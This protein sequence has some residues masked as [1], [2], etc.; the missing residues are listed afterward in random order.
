M[1]GRFSESPIDDVAAAVQIVRT[2]KNVLTQAAPSDRL[3]FSTRLDVT[4]G[5][6]FTERWDLNTSTIQRKKFGTGDAVT[7][8]FAINP[9]NTVSFAAGKARD[10][11]PS[12]EPNRADVARTIV[13]R[14]INFPTDSFSFDPTYFAVRGDHWRC[15]SRVADDT[16]ENVFNYTVEIA[17]AGGALTTCVQTITDAS[18]GH[19]EETCT[20]APGPNTTTASSSPSS[21]A[22][23]PVESFRFT[24]KQ[25][26]DGVITVLKNRAPGVGVPYPSSYGHPEAP[27]YEV[28]YYYPCVPA[29]ALTGTWVLSG[30]QPTE[31]PLLHIVDGPSRDNTVLRYSA[32]GNPEKMDLISHH[33]GVYTPPP[34]P[35][36][37]FAGR[38]RVL[39]DPAFR[40]DGSAQFRF[41][42]WFLDVN[43]IMM[44]RNIC[45]IGDAVCNDDNPV[46]NP[47]DPHPPS[48]HDA[49]SPAP[50]T[51]KQQQTSSWRVRG[52]QPGA[53]A[54]DDVIQFED[55]YYDRSEFT[56]L[57]PLLGVFHDEVGTAVNYRHRSAYSHRSY[58]DPR[59]GKS[60]RDQID[61]LLQTGKTFTQNVQTASFNFTYGFNSDIIFSYTETFDSRASAMAGKNQRRWTYVNDP[62]SILTGNWVHTENRATHRHHVA[63]DE[64][65]SG[66]FSTV[67]AMWSPE[68]APTS[69]CRI[70]PVARANAGVLSCKDAAT[71]VETDEFFTWTRTRP[72]DHIRI[73]LSASEYYDPDTLVPTVASTRFWIPDHFYVLSRSFFTATPWRPA[74]MV[75]RIDVDIERME[76]R[77]H[78][79][80]LQAWGNADTLPLVVPTVTVDDENS[81]IDLKLKT[82]LDGMATL[83]VRSSA[84]PDC[85]APLRFLTGRALVVCIPCSSYDS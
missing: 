31:S 59:T 25:G 1:L 10:V 56:T 28:H 36:V 44:R 7:V 41:T 72:L 22:A 47:E 24:Y 50:P 74:A 84:P 54:G 29:I 37:S 49:R 53:N 45:P 78:T 12:W 15:F 70:F 20:S 16:R 18:R 35:Q 14:P 51:G 33:H 82:T 4:G 83:K 55:T 38:A 75:Q 46:I 80:Q 52:S 71:G 66:H 23:E 77:A 69:E 19:G 58:E 17:G 3:S 11:V 5:D 32:A 81:R 42:Y 8:L 30:V 68:D 85:I 60:S 62:M 13:S 48:P 21:P 2:T 73:Q 9:D 26:A 43:T 40:D 76:D 65:Y 34:A 61:L 64:V 79:I 57:D 63:P 6:W 27:A 67:N 39:R